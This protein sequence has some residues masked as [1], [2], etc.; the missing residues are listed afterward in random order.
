MLSRLFFDVS[1]DILNLTPNRFLALLAAEQEEDEAVLKERLSS[2]SLNRLKEEGYCL[3]DLSAFWLQANQFGRP[4][5]SFS[6]GPGL[7]L[8]EHRFEC[9]Y[10]ESLWI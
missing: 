2:W 7:S 8:P 5:A 4:V 3:T 6:L 10:R 1:I 9:V